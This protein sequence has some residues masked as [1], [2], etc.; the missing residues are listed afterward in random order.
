MV[1][2]VFCAYAAVGRAENLDLPTMFRKGIPRSPFISVVYRYADTMLQHGRD[3]YGPQKTG[4]LL[5]ALDR[6]TLSP[7]KTRPAAPRGV[8][9]AIRPGPRGGPLAG[10]N[11]QTDQNVLRLLYFLV[12]LSGEDR[13]G[14][15]ADDALRWFLKNAASPQ[16]GMLPWDEHRCWN[17]LSDEIAAG[18][19]RSG[20]PFRGP[21][22][23]W[24]RCFQL[25]PEQSKRFAV[26]LRKRCLPDRGAAGQDRH[27]DS[28]Y[29]SPLP[30]ADCPRQVGF[31]VRT[32]A[33]AYAH[34][35]DEESLGAIRALLTR[36]E[37]LRPATMQSAR[38][39]P[40]PVE[41]GPELSLAID[42]DGAARKVPEPLRARLTGFAARQDRFFC[43]LPH[44]LRDKKGFLARV[45]PAA[46]DAGSARTPPWGAQHGRYTTAAIAM[47]CVSRYENTGRT[48]YRDLIVAAAE[49]YMDSLPGDSTDAW[50]LTFGHAISL[51]LAAFRAT[52]QRKYH[53]RAFRLGEVAVER[54][55]GDNPLPR[56]S[57]KT[58]HYES[59]TG[60]G[61]L[62]LALAELH[63]STL[64]IT[65]VRAPANTM[66]R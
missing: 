25:A 63:L 64:H 26:G 48:A 31:F 40:A 34:T 51:E 53:D 66:D 54:F 4:L 49:V 22:M 3:R 59:T 24:E 44:D 58:D 7:L 32:W 46:A 28:R 21:W 20:N 23:L 14:K 17:V 1:A 35:N 30:P 39:G 62:L 38:S 56:A 29:A 11:P 41:V 55:F 12:G 37:R 57:L 52:A 36:C 65:A 45:G 13:Y 10:A 42:C 15:A 33:E 61:T 47:M 9:A 18:A 60:A 50:P 16:T 43:S 27:V 2:C 19:G 5:S 6:K 8:P